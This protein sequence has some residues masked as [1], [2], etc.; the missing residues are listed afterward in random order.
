[1]SIAAICKQ[2]VIQ[3]LKYYH[4]EGNKEENTKF[5]TQKRKPACVVFLLDLP[6]VSLPL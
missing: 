5:W 4:G 2:A 6:V 3:V 1:M